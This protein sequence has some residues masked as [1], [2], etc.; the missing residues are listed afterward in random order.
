MKQSERFSLQKKDRD[1]SRR[2]HEKGLQIAER[3]SCARGI[4]TRKFHSDGH[5]LTQSFRDKR[6]LQGWLIW[7]PR[8]TSKNMEVM[9]ISRQ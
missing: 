9:Q 4:R 6:G 2:Q 1:G 7:T 3:F 8:S 5:R